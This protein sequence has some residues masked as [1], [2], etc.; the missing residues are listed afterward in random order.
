MSDWPRGGYPAANV[1]AS[2]LK[3]PPASMISPHRQETRQERAIRR[4]VAEEIAEALEAYTDRDR[5]M[6]HAYLD[7]ARIA[8]QIGSKE[9]E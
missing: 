4:A 1:P 3:P 2:E 6:H 5:T 9:A 8:R 7:A